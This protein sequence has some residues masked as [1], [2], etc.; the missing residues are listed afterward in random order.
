MTVEAR[1]MIR[2][3]LEWSTPGSITPKIQALYPQI[4]SKQVHF[5]WTEMSQELWKRD[6]AQLVSI[7]ILLKE[8]HREVD[9]FELEIDEGIQQVAFGM[10][11]IHE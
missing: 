3:G 6:P 1:D 10:K 4:S 7:E 8:Y 5:C 11:L 9:F 2:E